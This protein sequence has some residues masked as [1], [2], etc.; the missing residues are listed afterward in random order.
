MIQKDQKDSVDRY[1]PN[2]DQIQSHEERFPTTA[3]AAEKFNAIVE[4]VDEIDTE[5]EI[6]TYDSL[7]ASDFK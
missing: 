4:N 3:T 5:E 1:K 6:T 7:E 2:A